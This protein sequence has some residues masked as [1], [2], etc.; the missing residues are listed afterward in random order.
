MKH[1]RVRR[2]ICAGV[3]L[4]LTLLV[5]G[6]SPSF[7]E[8]KPKKFYIPPSMEKGSPVKH[9]LLKAP[10]LKPGE[11]IPDWLARWELAKVL[12]WKGDATSAMQMLEQVPEKNI[13]GDAT[14]LMGDLYMI[15]K[16]YKKAEQLYRTHLA[17][18]GDDHTVR[19]KLAEMLSWEKQYD[20]S[21]AEYR[22]ILE[23]LPDETQVRRRYAFVLIWS[24]KNAEAAQE[25]KKTLD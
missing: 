2:C 10:P 12:F 7:S 6:T 9:K 11:E 5:S 14:V 13:T 4:S 15:Q 1:S 17:T 3:L 16:N 21:L 25:L 24:G 18:H 20:A 23:A 19:L 8:E 22:K